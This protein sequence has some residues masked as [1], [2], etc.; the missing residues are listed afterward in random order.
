MKKKL[1]STALAGIMVMS[2]AACGGGG[3]NSGGGSADGGDA[4]GGA[5]SGGD[6]G[7]TITVAIWDNGQKAGLDQIIADY[8]AATGNK[9]E[10]QVITWDQYWTLLEAGA[11]GGDMPDVFWMHSNEVQKYMENDILMDL[12]DR[13]A[14]SEK[15]EMDKFPEDIKNLYSW[16]GKTYAIPKDVDTIALFYNKT[17]FD[18]AG[19]SYPDDS[20]TWDDFYDAAVKLTKEDGSQYGTAMNPSNEQDG[21]MNIIYSMGGKVLTDD[22]KA[23]GFDDPNTIKAMEFVQKLVDNVMPPATVMAETGTDVLLGSGKIAMLSQGSWMVPQFKEHEYI[24][25]NCDV[26]VLPKDPTTGN[27]VSLYNGLGWAVSAKTKNPDAAWQLVEWFGTKDMQL[28][29]AQLGV[30]MAAYD[31]VSDEWKNNTDKFDLQPFLDMRENIVFRP[32]TRATLTWWNPMCETFK[33][34]WNGNMPMADACAQVTQQ[35]NE[36]ISAE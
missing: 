6:K 5:S 22:K 31:G 33:E 17:M 21:W 23:S 29:Q 3:G 1:L 18:E 12:T 15:L 24:S 14:S 13:I 10:I 4:A 26:A 28:K 25:E 9:A 36:A 8:T 27:R 2:L 34:A 32:S 16:N 35:M 20:W 7:G 30:T 11:S 19:L